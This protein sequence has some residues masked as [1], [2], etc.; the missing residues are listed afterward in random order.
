MSVLSNN[1]FIGG[2]WIKDN[3]TVEEY[4]SKIERLVYLFKQYFSD[5]QQVKIVED[6][7]TVVEISNDTN[8]LSTFLRNEV[9]ID[10]EGFFIEIIIENEKSAISITVK[11]GMSELNK[12]LP[13]DSQIPNSFTLSFHQ[14]QINDIKELHILLEQL[15][16]IWKAEYITFSSDEIIDELSEEVE[17]YLI[18][19]VMYFD[20]AIIKD[21]NI[22]TEQEILL[23]NG[24]IIS[25]GFH[26]AQAFV[27][28]NLE[29][30]KALHR[31]LN[32]RGS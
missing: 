10:Q 2:Y 9:T 25:L 14:S 8:R 30:L 28:E 13:A 11:G 5:Y 29:K 23:E 7:K 22:T 3:F 18:G 32:K 24:K 16:R 20:K 31:K 12:K 17:D 4:Q 26:P 6:G 27:P 15:S 19:T 1:F 21:K